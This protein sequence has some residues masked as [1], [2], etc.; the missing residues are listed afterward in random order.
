MK[1]PPRLSSQNQ[2]QTEMKNSYLPLFCIFFSTLSAQRCVNYISRSKFCYILLRIYI[3]EDEANSTRLLI[4]ELLR[5]ESWSF[6][7]EYIGM[8]H[9]V[10]AVENNKTAA[11][12]SNDIIQHTVYTSNSPSCP[13]LL[14]T[15]ANFTIV[16]LPECTQYFLIFLSR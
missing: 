10:D 16:F 11:L 15:P 13:Q 14:Y 1:K 7:N 3:A 9:Y 12:V 4:G 6:L 2:C 5:D 8:V